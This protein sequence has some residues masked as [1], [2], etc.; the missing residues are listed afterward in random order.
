MHELSIAQALLDQVESIARER[1][2]ARA[3]SVTVRIGPLAG[4]E[5]ALLERAFE[6]ARL[7]SACTAQALLSV[8]LAVIRVRCDACGQDSERSPTCL[9][10]AHCGNRGTRLLEGD[11]LLLMQ[12]ALQLPCDEIEPGA[13]HV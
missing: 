5:P 2:A 9:S 6:V 4:V 12:V 10:C 13:S 1:G 7:R 11:E 8:E 3:A